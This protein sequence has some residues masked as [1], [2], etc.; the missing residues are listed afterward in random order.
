MGSARLR[1]GIHVLTNRGCEAG[2]ESS[3]GNCRRSLYLLS[4]DLCF[5]YD[6]ANSLYCGLAS[7]TLPKI[8]PTKGLNHDTGRAETTVLQ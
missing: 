2:R 3:R 8:L 6:E 4:G 7:E 1:V 5:S